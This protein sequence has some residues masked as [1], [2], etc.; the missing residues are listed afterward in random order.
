MRD[1]APAALKMTAGGYGPRFKAGAAKS[2][3]S[4]CTFGIG[5]VG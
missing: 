1:S 2:Y 3:S 5:C 4:P